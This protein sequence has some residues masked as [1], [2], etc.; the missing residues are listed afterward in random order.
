MIADNSQ[1]LLEQ[2]DMA[3]AKH[4]RDVNPDVK[5]TGRK[6]IGVGIY[7]F[8]KEIKETGDEE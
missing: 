6:A 4:D 7:Y 2:I 3:M 5:G 1:Q 8:E